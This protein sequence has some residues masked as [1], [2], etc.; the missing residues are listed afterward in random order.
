MK[1]LVPPCSGP[2]AQWGGRAAGGNS[3]LGK[4]ESGTFNRESTECY[5]QLRR[6]TLL[7]VAGIQVAQSLNLLPSSSTGI[8]NM[9][10]PVPLP[11]HANPERQCPRSGKEDAESVTQMLS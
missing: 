6:L 4:E 1:V 3:A 2:M 10:L 8:H 5:S 7:E 9:W 11:G